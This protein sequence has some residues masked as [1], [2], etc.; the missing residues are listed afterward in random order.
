[1][2][3]A[4]V[5]VTLLGPFTVKF[6]ERTAGPW[7]RPTA[8]RLCE[9]IMMN[10]GRR[11]SRE[12]AWE[13][14]F[15]DA[16]AVPSGVALSK[17]L[18]LA[19][20]SLSSL[21]PGASNLLQSDRAHIWVSDDVTISVD[22]LDHEEALRTALSLEPGYRRDAAL[23]MALAE[24]GVLL[25]EEPYADWALRPREAL[26]LLRQRARLVLARDRS[27]GHGQNRPE[28]VIDA[29]EACLGHDPACEEAASALIQAYCAEGWFSLAHKTHERCRTALYDLGLHVSSRLEVVHDQAAFQAVRPRLVEPSGQHDLCQTRA[30]SN[31]PHS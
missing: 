21:G 9:L 18:S 4:Q 10:I 23:V 6:G 14:I 2:V 13:V 20:R 25:E 24:E 11:T 26:E 16:T 15:P 28:D 29:W 22:F 3:D 31:A 1:M 27:E 5:E 17:A 12:W 30:L 19:R 8:K 7:G